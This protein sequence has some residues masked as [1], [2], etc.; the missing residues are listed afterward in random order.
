MNYSWPCTT[1]LMAI[2][3]GNHIGQGVN[4]SPNSFSVIKSDCRWI[5]AEVANK[6]SKRKNYQLSIKA[7]DFMKQMCQNPRPITNQCGENKGIAT[8]SVPLIGPL[9]YTNHTAT[10]GVLIL[11][12]DNLH[13]PDGFKFYPRCKWTTAVVWKRA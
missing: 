12:W 1:C 5:M 3:Q 10:F 9:Y 2:G 6:E 13:C 4:I 7:V 11:H 8:Y